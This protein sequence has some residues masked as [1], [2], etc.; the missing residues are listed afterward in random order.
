MGHVFEIHFHHLCLLISE[1]RLLTFKVIIK[2]VELISTIFITAL[3]LVLI[4]CFHC[5]FHFFK[6]P[7]VVLI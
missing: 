4:P 1:S 2:I 7:F 3:Y 5:V 6:I